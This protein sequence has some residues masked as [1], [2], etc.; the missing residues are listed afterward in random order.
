MSR[1]SAPDIIA[2][3]IR[4]IRRKARVLARS[5]VT[6]ANLIEDSP[7][8][9]LQYRVFVLAALSLVVDG[10]DTQAVAYVAPV[11]S[12]DWSL[13]TGAFGPVFAAGLIGSALGSIALAPWADR[14]V[15]SASWW[16]PPRLSDCSHYFAARRTRCRNWKRCASSQGLGSAPRFPMRLRSSRNMR[17]R[18]RERAS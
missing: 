3:S 12:K 7:L 4:Q 1:E 18:E 9:G 6:V 5:P 17:P 13:A 11:I 16:R 8:G 14:S 2:A 15:A 10:F